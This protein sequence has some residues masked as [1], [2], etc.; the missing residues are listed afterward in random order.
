MLK[1]SEVWY[2]VVR[3]AASLIA[4]DLI[5]DCETRVFANESHL[6]LDTGYWILDMRL[7]S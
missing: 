2:D 4:I 6:F 1:L 5:F 7:G 3:A